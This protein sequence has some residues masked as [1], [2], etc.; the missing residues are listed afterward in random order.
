MSRHWNVSTRTTGAKAAERR[1]DELKLQLQLLPF[2]IVAEEPDPSPDPL[3]QILGERGHFAVNDMDLDRG[4]AAL[5]PKHGERSGMAITRLPHA[6]DGQNMSELQ[7]VGP[8]K[9]MR[10][11]NCEQAKRTTERGAA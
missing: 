11:T 8:A 1:T 5:P 10:A 3:G 2:G 4:P 7:P 6:A 9:R